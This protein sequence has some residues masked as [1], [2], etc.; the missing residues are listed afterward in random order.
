MPWHTHHTLSV[1]LG[2]GQSVG[3]GQTHMI[4]DCVAPTQ[5]E[6]PRRRGAIGLDVASEALRRKTIGRRA[7][8][9]QVLDLGPERGCLDGRAISVGMPDPRFPRMCAVS[10]RR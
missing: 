6:P 3:A 2:I 9:D 1:V 5:L 8:A 10:L 7:K 4:R